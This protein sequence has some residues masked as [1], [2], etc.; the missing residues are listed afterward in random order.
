MTSSQQPLSALFTDPYLR[1]VFA[2]AERDTPPAALA[3]E[4]PR[5]PVLPPR[6]AAAAPTRELEL[7]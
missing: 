1:A 5:A 4:T 3:V 7:A 6:G 2:K